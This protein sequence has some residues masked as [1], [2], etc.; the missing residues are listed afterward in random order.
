MAEIAAATAAGREINDVY[1]RN[2]QQSGPGG[3]EALMEVYNDLE[4]PPYLR[5]LKPRAAPRENRQGPRVSECGE[6]YDMNE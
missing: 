3:V 1:D 6:V 5:P 2:E 4:L